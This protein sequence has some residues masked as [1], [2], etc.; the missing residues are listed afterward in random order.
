MRNRITASDAK[1]LSEE[2][3]SKKTDAEIRERFKLSKHQLA[4][5]RRKS[6]SSSGVVLASPLSTPEEAQPSVL[7]VVT[8]E[9]HK[10]ASCKA[11]LV[12]NM[13]FCPGCGG[14][15]QWSQM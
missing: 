10:C 6:Q 14:K 3:H 1:L 9:T 7:E 5:W 12:E 2:L 11:E 15:L 8:K 13:Q 4:Y